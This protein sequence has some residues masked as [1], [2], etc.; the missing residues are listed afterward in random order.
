MKYIFVITFTLLAFVSATSSYFTSQKE[1]RAT[2]QAYPFLENFRPE[3]QWPK[4]GDCWITTSSE[5]PEDYQIHIYTPAGWQQLYVRE[6]G[7]LIYRTK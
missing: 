2:Q 3:G 6:G 5:T 4:L 1:N 7:K